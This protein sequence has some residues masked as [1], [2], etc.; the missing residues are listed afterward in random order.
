MPLPAL[1][2]LSVLLAILGGQ[3]PTPVTA[4]LVRAGASVRV[5][6]NLSGGWR[7]IAA[8]G[9]RATVVIAP[10]SIDGSIHA[11]LGAVS[12]HG[13][14]LLMNV[15][16]TTPE[17][18]ELLNSGADS[19]L[20]SVDPDEAV[21][22][23]AAALRRSGGPSATPVPR[24]LC[25][26]DLRLDL[27]HRTATASGLTLGLTPLEFDLL[28]YFIAHAGESLSRNRLLETVWGYDIGDRG[29]VTVHVRR[30]RVKI[31]ADPSC[32]S[33]LQT[34]WGIGYRFSCDHPTA[35]PSGGAA[36]TLAPPRPVR[37]N[38]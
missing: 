2:G 24:V 12:R 29:T 23:L 1:G 14:V 5:V 3:D 17:R 20:A 6:S 15:D 10:P 27:G 13:C 30:L 8:V 21:A 34:V 18:I 25:S 38:A 32:P 33:L 7:S 28:A 31:E 16:A 37:A 22:A 36:A 11:H 9:P 26:G 35:H 4:A 19:V